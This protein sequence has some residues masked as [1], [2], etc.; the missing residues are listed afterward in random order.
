MKKLF[1]AANT[2]IAIV[3]GVDCF[4]WGMGLSSSTILW[5]NGLVCGYIFLAL[6]TIVVVGFCMLPSL[7]VSEW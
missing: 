5:H 2:I 1:Y 6:L 3:A 4:V 7:M